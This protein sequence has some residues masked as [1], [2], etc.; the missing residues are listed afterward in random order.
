LK[1]TPG[2]KFLKDLQILKNSSLSKIHFLMF[3]LFILMIAAEIDGTLID[4]DTVDALIEKYLP[5]YDNDVLT[6]CA[7]IAFK[8]QQKRTPFMHILDDQAKI[9]VFVRAKAAFESGR[10]PRVVGM[11]GIMNKERRALLKAE[12]KNASNGGKKL[13][14]SQVNTKVSVF[15]KCL[16]TFCF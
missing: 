8:F 13:S 1:K 7:F 5:E 14:L 6:T 16:S 11:P 15:D 10:D 9:E 2:Q 4:R 3:L 12:T